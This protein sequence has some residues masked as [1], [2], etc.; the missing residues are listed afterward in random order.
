MQQSLEDGE[1][2]AHSP[3]QNDGWLFGAGDAK[4]GQIVG[5]GAR[6]GK[7]LKNKF[8]QALPAVKH[9][10]KA[11]QKVYKTRGYLLGLDGGRITLKSEHSALNYLLQGAEAVLMKKA[12]LIHWQLLQE[13]GYV[14]GKDVAKV[15]DVHDE[16][17]WTCRPEIADHVGQLGIQSIKLS[18]EHFGFR[19]PLD[20]EYKIGNNWA[21]VH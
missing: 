7:R 4:I 13:A 5:K 18:G 11:V 3:E 14:W 9:L 2:L 12:H 6:E 10:V 16:A 21:D 19:C 8:M 20:G 15:S 1:S 17:A